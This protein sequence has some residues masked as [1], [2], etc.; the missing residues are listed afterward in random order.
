MSPFYGIAVIEGQHQVYR[1]TDGIEREYL[2]H[3]AF[4]KPRDAIRYADMR[5]AD[6]QPLR[7]ASSGAPD[8]GP[9]TAPVSSVRPSAG[10]K[11]HASGVTASGRGA[12]P[13]ARYRVPF[14]R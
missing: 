14:P 1:T 13:E 6:V 2:P 11:A 8:P 3:A 12:S 4:G 5:Q 7:P 9:S 10:R